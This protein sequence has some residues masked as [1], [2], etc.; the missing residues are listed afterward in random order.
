MSKITSKGF[1]RSTLRACNLKHYG[2]TMFRMIKLVRL[3]LSVNLP[4]WTNTLA[5]HMLREILYPSS[6]IVEVPPIDLNYRFLAPFSKLDHLKKS[7]K[8]L[9]LTKWSSLQK[10]F[11][12]IPLKCFLGDHL[13]PIKNFT[14]VSSGVT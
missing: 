4:A 10:G 11:R 9:T 7:E 8:N 2:L 5:Y 12:K 3:V 1:M 13:Y 14:R 6:F